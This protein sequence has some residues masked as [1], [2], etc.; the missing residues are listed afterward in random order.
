MASDIDSRPAR[1]SR[2]RHRARQAGARASTWVYVAAAG[3]GPLLLLGLWVVFGLELTKAVAGMT[4]QEQ[5]TLL[6]FTGV[7]YLGLR[8]VRRASYRWKHEAVRGS[9]GPAAGTARLS[10]VTVPKDL[11]PVWWELC[12]SYGRQYASWVVANR[13]AGAAED[14]LREHARRWYTEWELAQG[15]AGRSEDSKAR[16]EAAHAV[17][18][19]VLGCTVTEVSIV[20]AAA[21]DSGGRTSIAMPVPRVDLA[22]Q[23]FILMSVFLAGRD[24]DTVNAL[25]DTGSANDMAR[26]TNAAAAVISTG[27]RPEAYD[28]PL[29]T[30]G[31]VAAAAQRTTEILAE[32]R[33]AVEAIAVALVDAKVIGGHDL[34]RHLPRDVA[35]GERVKLR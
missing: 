25:N 5:H 28:G 3:V 19:Y 1:E 27:L 33:D 21:D 7:V 11:M 8:A 26:L 16:H 15:G 10:A 30:D 17:V 2:S 35:T 20:P 18:A 34:R 22:T 12:A 32:R 31:L 23:S 4:L 14:E 29:T 6:H 9:A 24:I 13:G